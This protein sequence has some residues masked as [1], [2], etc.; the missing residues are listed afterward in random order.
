MK[1]LLSSLPVRVVAAIC[2][3]VLV[4]HVLPLEA[5]RLFY[6]T[7]FIIKELLEFFLPAIVFFFITTGVIAFRKNSLAM[8]GLLLVTVF[9]SN[10]LTS[11]YTYIMGRAFLS[12][13]AEQKLLCATMNGDLLA[14]YWSL[15]IGPLLRS[16]QA[17]IGALALGVML[18][19]IS[20][21]RV[22]TILQRGKRAI[23]WG[24]NELFI[25]LLPLYVFGFF[26]K[27]AYE[28]P[29][30]ELCSLYG[31]VFALA[32]LLQL[33]Y[34]V[35]AYIVATGFVV[36][37]AVRALIIAAPS[38]LTAL[39]T[40]SSVATLPVSVVCAEKNSKNKSLS[41]FAMPILANI[42]LMGDAVCVPLF[43]I[44]TMKAFYGVFPAFGVYALFIGYFCLTMLA[45]SGI[46]GGGIIVMLPLLK[47][48]FGF[49]PEMLSVM[50]ALYLLQD[51]F[52]TAAN[53]MG[54]GALVLILNRLSRALRIQSNPSKGTKHVRRN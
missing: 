47:S 1:Q 44:A 27:M 40:M 3:A 39:G 32:I 2:G 18:T 17:M 22:E 20:A 50:T 6:T 52:G 54:D 28:L 53:V 30:W 43:C 10:S 34:L 12:G 48:L 25:P 36:R 11:L 19:F 14:P 23:E 45:V 37:D 41:Q 13:L 29:V 46:P 7:S 33:L 51:G 35:G 15:G 5:L 26:L 21:P 16:E 49:S 9:C 4:A 31:L 24:M 38:Y 8:I 42:H